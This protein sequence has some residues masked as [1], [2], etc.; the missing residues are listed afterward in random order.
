MTGASRES[1]RRRRATTLAMLVLA[2]LATARIISTYHVFSQTW[3]EPGHLAAGMEWWERGTYTYDRSHPPLSRLAIALGPFLEGL[4]LSGRANTWVVQEGNH[5][6]HSRG[7]YFRNLTLARLGAL[8]FFL[9][10]TYVVWVWSRRLFGDAAALVTVLLFT[11]LPPVLAHAGLATTDVPLMATFAGAMLAFLSWL[12]RPTS[13]CSVMLGVAVGLAILSKLSALFFLPACGLAILAWRRVIAKDATQLPHADS[14]HRLT[15]VGLVTLSALLVIWAGYRFS[16]RPFTTVAERPHEIV[17][18]LVG[19]EGALHHLA[20]R[21]AETMPIPARELIIGISE[22]QRLNTAGWTSYLLGEIRHGGWWY[23]F[24]VALAVKSPLAFLILTGIGLWILS[25]QALRQRTWQPMA[26]AV[27]A[28]ILL[29][30]CL[31]IRVNVGLRYLLPIYPLLA[32][33]AGIGAVALWQISRPRLIGPAAVVGLLAWQVV[34]SASIHPDYLAYFN[35]L[36]GRHPDRILLDSDLDWGQDLLRLADTL[37]AR[38]VD[39]V[40]IAYNGSADLSRHGFPRIRPLI[41][42][43]PTTGWIAISEMRLKMGDGRP[44]YD[45]FLWLDAYKPV[46]MV[47]RSIRLYYVPNTE[48][49]GVPAGTPS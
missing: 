16:L 2:G 40:A 43:Q 28:I 21:V 49:A 45:A 27:A 11:T 44:P 38:G 22:V 15:V 5:I 41:P 31:T 42:H 39:T 48:G 37:R 26:P 17:D 36:A 10:A 9:L 25:R 23:F 34:S 6:L 4:R 20:Y 24:P 19:S 13:F 32:I 33:V 12:D 7:A 14:A 1:A 47:G 18:R 30:V 29:I 3:D 8:P 46:T 35:E